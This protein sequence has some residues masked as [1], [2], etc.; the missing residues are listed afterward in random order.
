MIDDRRLHRAFRNEE[1]R[2]VDQG[3][4]ARPRQVRQRRVTQ[5]EEVVDAQI[6]SC[7]DALPSECRA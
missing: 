2:S 5:L 3:H 4:V 1:I 7:L 6:V